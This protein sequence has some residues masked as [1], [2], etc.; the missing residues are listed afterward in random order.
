MGGKRSEPYRITAV[1]YGALASGADAVAR[2]TGVAVDRIRSLARHPDASPD[3]PAILVATDEEGIAARL[4]L[5]P[6]R[7]RI[8]GSTHP[9]AWAS[10]WWTRSDAA[11]AGAALFFRASRTVTSFGG[12]L[13]SAQALRV[14]RAARADMVSIPRWVLVRRA[15]PF[16]ARSLAARGARS[17][18]AIMDAVTTV[19]R[20]VARRPRFAGFVVDEVER[21]DEGLDDIDSLTPSPRTFIRGSRELDWVSDTPWDVG[22]NP[23]YR[24]FYLRRSGVRPPVA[25][26]WVRER[27]FGAARVASVMRTAARA[28]DDDVLSA[29]IAG[30]LDALAPG[31]IDL[32]DIAGAG[33]EASRGA[34]SLG[35]LPYGRIHA[36]C[37]FATTLRLP[38]GAARSFRWNM[39]EGDVIFL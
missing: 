8:D 3:H 24:R 7:M 32:V 31:P 37:I 4:V 11:G 9:I 13:L 34:F 14:Y 23:R 33:P 28:G 22:A 1:A 20:A 6:G 2:E 18:A 36:G 12:E 17:L 19:H 29:L 26:A 10:G 39:A 30:V 21:W 5:I 27:S 15:A 16:L 35:F 38:A 25:Y